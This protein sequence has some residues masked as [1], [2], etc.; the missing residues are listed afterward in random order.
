MRNSLT[1]WVRQ[2]FERS[3]LGHSWIDHAEFETRLM[4]QICLLNR[5]TSPAEKHRKHME[6]LVKIS[7]ENN[8]NIEKKKTLPWVSGGQVGEQRARLQPAA[9]RQAPSLRAGYHCK[10]ETCSGGW[11]PWPRAL[12]EET[13]PERAWSRTIPSDDGCCWLCTSA[14]KEELLK[15]SNKGQVIM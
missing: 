15:T 2:W 10:C 6:V 7:A 11:W 8:K 9:P 4:C 14:E 1:L 13:S 12:E 3:E 5:P